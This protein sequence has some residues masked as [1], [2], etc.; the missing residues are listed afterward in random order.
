[1]ENKVE[2]TKFTREQLLK[3]KRYEGY[4]DLLCAL[5]GDGESCTL[6]E[7]DKRISSFLSKKFK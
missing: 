6:K 1:M 2:E 3:S 4:R 5:V 7:T